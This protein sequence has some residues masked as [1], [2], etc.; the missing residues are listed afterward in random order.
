LGSL[1]DAFEVSLL[2]DTF[3][4]VVPTFASHAT[5][6]LNATSVGESPT[7][8]SGIGLEVDGNTV[9]LDISSLTAGEEVTLYVDLV[10][11]QP[12]TGSVATVG[13]FTVTPETAYLESFTT[14]AFEGPFGETQG[15]GTCDVNGD[16]HSD[17]VI[18]DAAIGG[19]IE[20]LNDGMGG[21]ARNEQGDGEGESTNRTIAIGEVVQ[22]SLASNSEVDTFTFEADDGQN[23]FF[24]VQET[25]GLQVWTLTD[26]NGVEV[27]TSGL[28]DRDVTPIQ[29][30]GT[31]TLTVAGFF[32]AQGDYQFQIHDVPDT[33]VI[34][35]E[36]G[37]VV[38]ERLN[39]PGEQVEFTFNGEAD[40]SLYFDSLLQVGSMGWTLTSPSGNIEFS[41]TIQDHDP[42]SLSE[43][44]T[45]H[46]L[47]DGDLDQIGDFEFR[48]N[49]VTPSLPLP[50]ALD[51]EITG[52]VALAGAVSEYTFAANA[53]QGIYLDSQA[54]QSSLLSYVLVDGINQVI[55]EGSF[56]DSGPITIPSTG[57]FLLQIDGV[58]DATEDFR[59]VLWD[60]PQGASEPLFFVTPIT[61]SIA[62]PGQE[63][64]YHFA[65]DAGDSIEFDAIFGANHL[66]SY[67][68]LSPAGTELF[69]GNDDAT[70]ASLPESGTY[71]LLVDGFGDAIGDY[72]FRI[73]SDPAP[74]IDDV[75]DLTISS[76][77][78]PHNIVGAQSTVEVNWEV[79]NQGS[80]TVPA[81]TRLTTF[82]HLSS[83]SDL[84]DLASSPRIHQSEW[85]LESDLAPGQSTPRSVTV[86]LPDGLNADMEILVKTDALNAVFENQLE[87]NNVASSKIAIY[88]E[89]NLQGLPE[90]RF[91]IEDRTELPSGVPI[92]ISGSTSVPAGAVN[93]IFMLD[94]SGSTQLIT[95]LDANFDGIAD[96]ADDL[97][98][99]GRIGD[100]LD[101]EIGL[102]QQTVS[103][104]QE[105]VSDLRVAVVAW[106]M[107]NAAFPDAGEALDLGS[108]RFNQTFVAP[109][110][111]SQV[112]GD[113]QAA[114]ASISIREQGLI[115]FAGADLFR[116][117]VIGS[118]NNYDEALQ[119][120]LSILDVAPDAD[121]NHI[122]F[123]TDGLFVP[124]E[125]VVA[126]D[127]TI[128]ALSD[129]DI[130]F[131]AAQV[132]GPELVTQL[133]AGN[134]PPD[135][136]DSVETGDR[137]VD[138][139]LRIVGGID[140]GPSTASIVLADGPADLNQVIL[141]ETRIAGVTVNGRAAETLDPAGGFFS[142]QELQP[143]ENIVTARVIDS[144]GNAVDRQLLLV[145]SSDEPPEFSQLE[146][147]SA[148]AAVQFTGTTWNRSLQ[149][150]YA[151]ARVENV[152][153]HILTGP[154]L[155]TMQSI[156]TPLLTLANPTGR[157]SDTPYLEFSSE[158]P[159]GGLAP[160]ASSL[161]S[162][163]QFDNPNLERFSLDVQFFSNGNQS[164]RFS[165]A[166]SVLAAS[167]E[168]YQYDLKALDPE[169]H[170]LE[171]EL[172]SGPDG[173][174]LG[175]N[176]GVLSW[177]PSNDQLGTHPVQVRAADPFGG[178][179]SQSFHIT[180]D[181]ELSN[182]PPLFQSA[183][184]TQISLGTN[185]SYTPLA[186]DPDGDD[187][188]IT[189]QT[190]PAGM[191]L[192][193]STI[194]WSGAAE[195]DYTV[196]LKATDDAGLSST[197]TFVLTIG[198]SA[199]NPHSPV[200]L[201]SPS[202]FAAVGI[203]YFYLP[204]AQDPDGDG[205][206]FSLVTAPESALVDEATGMI[207][208]TPTDDQIGDHPFLLQVADGIGGFA[209]QFFTVEV[210]ESPSN[211]PPV[212]TSLPSVVTSVGEAYSYAAAA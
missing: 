24:D 150:L 29:L 26:P 87:V 99:D 154:L 112:D 55:R 139:V 140:Q 113:F 51:A 158:I 167:E 89:R 40:Q 8:R 20:F 120:A 84:L 187:V 85:V 95:G 80:A 22:D 93:A 163:V 107:S 70:I 172:V 116:P 19:F 59:F 118:G 208:W 104:L 23:L 61:G 135:W 210:S 57:E 1:P 143:G 168:P 114:L 53:G 18:E 67:S 79:N 182:R 37:N 30:S 157:S 176:S 46:L 5:A 47:I 108:S 16:G 109:G 178:V 21:F 196:E 211:F 13:G 185:Y 3:Q 66:V 146:E 41:E 92:T 83:T 78:A 205:L 125:D 128:D 96:N 206:T 191:V 152:G 77:Q 100:L 65:A 130:R 15:V 56:D 82:L 188:V 207:R 202:T 144:S 156:G 88:S 177:T 117:F 127:S 4:S 62:V 122:Y 75:P 102:V 192:A 162:Q 124:N 159:A 121:A 11:N 195:G 119:E 34:P 106:G 71:S 50:I 39:V 32:G 35:T 153:H 68:L 27:F 198:D 145:G 63:H 91:N 2:D 33:S 200:I 60:V 201:S 166:P 149:R 169:G 189:L 180:V 131:R 81:G 160:G 161:A 52:A 105:T 9:S 69:S 28:T 138:E 164:P 199:S 98:G 133:C 123:F 6:F 110:I 115:E 141:P 10:G 90:L 181:S 12:G 44:G 73:L 155:A 142:V 54:G 184:T 25:T 174:Q 148:Q 204:L 137:Y 126:E 212:F 151:D 209:T 203:P 17:V 173:M 36:I 94:L 45:Y 48:I 43:S 179:T 38:H 175:R 165:S 42:I 64:H 171:Y 97:N 170:T 193:D 129:R 49:D 136:C 132:A 111:D 31:Y 186:I 7:I 197:Q 74:P 103:R 72:S 194:T 86:T 14:S 76:L 101:K 190:A 147:V 134:T 183:P 58:G